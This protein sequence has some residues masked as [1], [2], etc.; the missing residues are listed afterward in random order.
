MVAVLVGSRERGDLEVLETVRETVENV[1]AISAIADRVSQMV[2]DELPLQERLA[3]LEGEAPC[4][5][6]VRSF[7]QYVQRVKRESPPMD[8][9]LLRTIQTYRA[10][11]DLWRHMSESLGRR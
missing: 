11:L 5:D 7:V 4:L 1:C 2:A 9:L 10:A 3:D 6:R 8:L